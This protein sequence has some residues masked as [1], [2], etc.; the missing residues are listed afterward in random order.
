MIDFPKSPTV[1]YEK[2]SGDRG[3]SLTGGGWAFVMTLGW[4]APGDHARVA[5]IEVTHLPA[6]DE[7]KIHMPGNPFSRKRRAATAPGTP[8]SASKRGMPTAAE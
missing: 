2:E 4:S 8:P 3:C 5:V 1:L 6:L 7:M